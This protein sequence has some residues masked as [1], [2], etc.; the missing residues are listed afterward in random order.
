MKTGTANYGTSGYKKKNHFKLKDGDSIFRILPPLGDLAE[1][2]V[3]SRFYAVHFGYKNAEGKFRTFVSPEVSKYDKETKT[4][5]IEVRDAALDRLND[6]KEKLEDAKAKNNGPLSTKLNTL[7]GFKGVY[8]LDKNHHMNV[9][10]LDGTIGELKIR[11]KAKLAL[12]TEI[13]KLRSQ[14]IDPLSLDN[15]RFF[16]FTRTG[17]GND[18]GFKVTVYTEELDVPGVGLVSRPIVSKVGADILGRLDSEAFDLD[19]LFAQPTAE[20]VAKIVAESDL[21]TGKSAGVDRYI[22][23]PWN[24]KNK[25]AKSQSAEAANDDAAADYDDNYTSPPAKQTLTGT[26]TMN[27]TV[28]VPSVFTP[29]PNGGS[30][31]SAASTS[32]TQVASTTS[33]KSQAQSVEELSDADFFAQIGVQQ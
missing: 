15:G 31:T 17:N 10:A 22:D 5:T 33:V 26:P 1:K 21:L 2:G 20:E 6:L 13:N 16:V 11:H 27:N 18:T 7:V 32:T 19:T 3:W 8:S 30:P 29:S 12:D 4:R 23:A 28:P 9:V 25:S 24:A 14:G